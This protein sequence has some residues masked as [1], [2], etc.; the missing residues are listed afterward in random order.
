VSARH[1]DLDAR[2]ESALHAYH[3]GE[4]RG[5]ARWRFARRL[6]RSPAL[7]RELELLRAMRAALAEADARAPAP[8]LWDAISRRLP[9]VEA[10]ASRSA[11]PSRVPGLWRPLGAVAAAAAVAA[12]AL[13]V[14]LP[15]QDGAAGAVRWIDSG[16]RNV[17]VFDDEDLTIIW[18]LDGAPEGASRGGFR[19]FS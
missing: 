16:E 8:D 1:A 5:F 10:A 13:R 9:A 18:V 11:A 4:L 14:L 7:A 15:A 2:T 6:A 12:L 3:D 19:A 17:I